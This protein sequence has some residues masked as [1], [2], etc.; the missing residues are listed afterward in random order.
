MQLRHF[1]VLKMQ[2]PVKRELAVYAMC[3]HDN[4]FIVRCEH[5]TEEIYIFLK[6]DSVQSGL[7]LVQNND[8]SFFPAKQ[9]LG[10]Q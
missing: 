9:K 8:G 1:S 5:V 10:E 6:H 3:C 7:G 4:D 2:Y